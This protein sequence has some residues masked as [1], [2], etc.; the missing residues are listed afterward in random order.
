MMYFY[1]F[2]SSFVA[3][4][5]GQTFCVYMGCADIG[6]CIYDICGLWMV[7]FFFYG[8]VS[9]AMC[10]EVFG[11]VFGYVFGVMCMDTGSRSSARPGSINIGAYLSLGPVFIIIGTYSFLEAH[12][13]NLWVLLL[14]EVH[15]SKFWDLLLHEACLND[16]PDFS[17]FSWQKWKNLPQ[18]AVSNKFF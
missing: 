7:L 18:C 9:M 10:M 2:L 14:H 12:F 4:Y 11:H 16:P 6:Y 13:H 5:S 17:N 3:L 1:L 15:F 8:Y